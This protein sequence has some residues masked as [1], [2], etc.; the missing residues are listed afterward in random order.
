MNCLLC[1]SQ[2]PQNSSEVYLRPDCGIL[3]V[4]NVAHAGLG[5]KFLKQSLSTLA[6]LE[7]GAPPGSAS[8]AR[9]VRFDGL[10]GDGEGAAPPRWSGIFVGGPRPLWLLAHRGTFI[11]HPMDVEGPVFG[12]SPFNN[13]NCPEVTSKILSPAGC[14]PAFMR[15][16]YLL[17]L[18]FI[19]L[20]A[21][22]FKFLMAI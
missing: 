18:N 12:M 15:V 11:P 14:S 3:E 7:L 16:F 13:L 19:Y 21:S 9:M 4:K 1:P 20:F 10:C 2:E 17:H 5:I 22:V 6:L 8:Q